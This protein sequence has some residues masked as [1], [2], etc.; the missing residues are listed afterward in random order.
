MAPIMATAVVLPEEGLRPRKWF[1]LGGER[2]PNGQ[3]RLC[4]DFYQKELLPMA[5]AR[6]V[7]ITS[8]CV[9]DVFEFRVAELP[10]H[11]LL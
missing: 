7:Y 11:A 10:L 6:H 8:W 5:G 1:Q 4:Q 2:P 3:K 9:V